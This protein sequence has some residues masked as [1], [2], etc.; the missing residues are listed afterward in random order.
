MTVRA[1]EDS[2]FA[3]WSRDRH[4]FSPDGVVDAVAFDK[5]PVKILLVMKEVNDD[6]RTNFDLRD[7]LK[8]GNHPQS[9]DAVARWVDGINA[10]FK[11][12]DAPPWRAVEN[13]TDERRKAAMGQLVVV[14][15]K[16]AAG[17]HTTDNRSLARAANRDADFLRRQLALYRPDLTICCGSAVTTA[18]VRNRL[19]PLGG[20]KHT[21]RGV[22]YWRSAQ[23]G[24]VFD[25]SHPSARVAPNLVLYGLLEAV[26]EA[27]ATGVASG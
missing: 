12:Q 19:L 8:Q 23:H 20:E 3:E 24:V 16:K 15:V 11:G 1:Q 17:T 22:R 25:F 27:H 18:I 2:L 5:A 14:N 6:E 10:V 26:A 4:S 7:F 9:W 21:T 13:V